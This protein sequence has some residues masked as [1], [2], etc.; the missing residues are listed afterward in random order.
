MAPQ[1]QR[2][3]FESWYRALITDSL[4]PNQLAV[5]QTMV[6]DRQADTLKNAAQFLDWKESV[7]DPNEH[8]YGF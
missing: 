3:A 7:V 8:M 4:T 6:D 1:H 5:L 2:K